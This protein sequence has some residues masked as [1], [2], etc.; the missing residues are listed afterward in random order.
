MTTQIVNRYI[1]AILGL[2]VESQ[3]KNQVSGSSFVRSP[4]QFDTSIFKSTCLVFA[5][6]AESPVVVQLIGYG[7]MN[8]SFMRRCYAYAI[9]IFIFIFYDD[10]EQSL[11][12]SIID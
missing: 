1:L 3:E 5:I 10:V 9:F 2:I 12:L 4:L 7:D 8:L 11:S 6:H